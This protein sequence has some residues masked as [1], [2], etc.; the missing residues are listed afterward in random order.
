MFVADET[1]V[2]I[3]FAVARERLA[4]LAAS[5]GLLSISEDAYGHESAHLMRV[6]VG[7]LSKM[8]RVQVRELAWTETSAGLA[9]RWEATGPGGGLFPAL[10][11]DIRLAPTE[12]GTTLLTIVG[13]YRPPL[14]SLGDALDRTVLH[15]VAAATIRRFLAKL[16][17]HIGGSA[18]AHQPGLRPL[19]SARWPSRAAR[20]RATGALCRYRVRSRRLRACRPIAPSPTANRA[21]ARP[22]ASSVRFAIAL[23]GIGGSARSPAWCTHTLTVLPAGAPLGA[24]TGPVRSSPSGAC[25]RAGVSW[26][27]PA[28]GPLRRGAA[29]SRV[30]GTWRSTARRTS[31]LRD[32][33]ASTHR[34]AAYATHGEPPRKAVIS[35]PN[36]AVS[37]RSDPGRGGLPG[38]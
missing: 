1:S 15:R 19:A 23:C 3:S 37:A 25:H 27:A 26:I 32:S 7:G 18:G 17:V 14:G 12:E 5:D 8:V 11:A 24:E 28:P 31:A 6:A 4:Q 35:V 9:I 2:E 34:P 36:T 33:L 10:D 29:C 16:A 20:M 21:A 38:R 22:W 13:S 30:A